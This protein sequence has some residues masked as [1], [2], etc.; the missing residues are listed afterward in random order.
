MVIERQ[1][2]AGG[3]QKDIIIENAEFYGEHLQSLLLACDSWAM[4]RVVSC[5][6]IDGDTVQFRVSL[7]FDLTEC[8]EGRQYLADI[9]KRNNSK[10][11]LTDWSGL[12][13]LMI[14]GTQLTGDRLLDT[15]PIPL[16]LPIGLYVVP[17]VGFDLRDC[18]ESR[19]RLIN[20]RER[21]AIQARMQKGIAAHLAIAEL[22]TSC[23]SGRGTLH[24]SYLRRWGKDEKR[25]TFLPYEVEGRVFSSSPDHTKQ[26]VNCRKNT[27]SWAPR[28]LGK[29]GRRAIS[30]IVKLGEWETGRIIDLGKWVAH[31]PVMLGWYPAKVTIPVFNMR[32]SDSYHIELHAPE[33]IRV[34][35]PGIF[36]EDNDK[37][38]DQRPVDER[39]LESEVTQ[40]QAQAGSI[41]WLPEGLPPSHNGSICH[42]SEL[43]GDNYKDVNKDVLV[44]RAWLSLDNRL[45]ATVAFLAAINL[46]ISALTQVTFYYDAY[47]EVD[48]VITLQ[49]MATA[50]SF[51]FLYVPSEHGL[52]RVLYGPVRWTLVVITTLA[53][54][55]AGS[56][57]CLSAQLQHGTWPVDSELSIVVKLSA[58]AET[59][60]IFALTICLLVTWF[61]TRDRCVHRLINKF[62]KNGNE[63]PAKYA[64]YGYHVIGLP[65][66]GC[67]RIKGRAWT[68][69][70]SAC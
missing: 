29:Y 54:I 62:T 53:L 5:T 26:L 63:N 27:T 13:P 55:V 49:V 69:V 11:K 7:D 4:R 44:F 66:R 14:S 57:S 25:F 16:L 41:E 17:F 32:L 70:T 9:Q 48:A 68:R 37:P 1:G 59:C 6:I 42:Y 65:G 58:L 2:V 46:V 19:I 20:R 31:R 36:V 50:A 51:F 22:P 33:G 12:S 56:L 28:L 39:T 18:G 43:R 64:K 23:D 52:S 47:L 35:R 3:L 38:H 30:A 67:R 45:T 15:F 60:L 34:H 21:D 61:R 40:G 24:Y 10:R 8:N